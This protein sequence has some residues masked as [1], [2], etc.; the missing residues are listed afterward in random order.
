MTANLCLPLAGSG[1]WGDSV[2]ER[3]HHGLSFFQPR[4]SRWVVGAL[5]AVVLHS[6]VVGAALLSSSSAPPTPAAL[7]AAAPVFIDL[8]A[9]PV[10]PPAPAPLVQPAP[11]PEPEPQHDEAVIPD[12]PTLEK[13][14]AVLPP[15]KPKP[16]PVVEKKQPRKPVVKQQETRPI[17]VK[18][19]PTED[20]ESL[21]QADANSS[22]AQ[23]IAAAPAVGAVSAAVRQ[24]Q[25]QSWQA[26]VLS[27]LERKKRYPRMAQI[28]QQQGVVQVAFTVSRDGTVLA[29]SLHKASDYD[30]LNSEALDLPQRVSP[31]P[32]PPDGVG[33]QTVRIV[34]PIQFFLKR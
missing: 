16:K 21:I 17:P 24:Q 2:L 23:A 8:A 25:Q 18:Q 22:S 31:V 15:S 27:H 5:A 13:P 14:E 30:V 32:A 11:Q 6:A 10:L 9:L 3:D 4:R 19:P 1:Q 12:L 7:P 20:A 26:A 28:Y 29:T 33:G 34:V